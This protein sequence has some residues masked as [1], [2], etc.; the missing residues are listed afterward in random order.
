MKRERGEYI[1]QRSHVNEK[2]ANNYIRGS[3]VRYFSFVLHSTI[4]IIDIFYY[5]MRWRMNHVNCEFNTEF[6]Q[7]YSDQKSAAGKPAYHTMGACYEALKV[8]NQE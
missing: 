8:I 2:C 4:V 7:R 3:L 6:N 5:V 1:K